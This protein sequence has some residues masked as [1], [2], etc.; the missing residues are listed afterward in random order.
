MYNNLLTVLSH[1]LHITVDNNKN[2]LQRL[3]FVQYGF[4]RKEHAI[5]IRPHGNSKKQGSF[6][7]TKPSVLKLMKKSLKENKRPL[8]VLREV[9]NIHGGI[10]SAKSSC[11]LPR[12]RRQIYNAKQTSKK[13]DE[14]QSKSVNCSDTLAHVMQLCKETSS[15]KEAIVHSVVAAPE[16]MC[17][18]ATNQQLTDLER[19]C[20]RTPCSVVSIDPTFN[21]GPF[22]VTPTTYHNLL[23]TTERGN[24]PIN[25]GPILI[26]QTKTFQPFHYFVS[27][28]VRLN[29]NLVN[30][31]A[32]GTDGESELIKAFSVTFPHA[33][34]LRCTNHMRQN[35]KD[36]LR[37]LGISQTVMSEFIAD[38]FGKQTGNHFETGLIDCNSKSS[39]KSVLSKLMCR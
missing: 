7:L 6:K 20:T 21:L 34:H 37:S 23:V 36:K 18:L 9:E 19:F 16:P 32:F 15:S 14:S 29:P 8:R 38:I 26:H 10:M 13:D 30:L 17:V 28:L 1:C 3:A 27:T 31:R 24:H 39:F 11:D 4:D 35:I 25:L 22:Y 33:V 2:T 12:N 5:D